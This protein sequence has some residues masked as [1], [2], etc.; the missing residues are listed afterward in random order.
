LNQWQTSEKAKSLQMQPPLGS[1]TPESKC[2][3]GW[4]R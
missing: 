1:V 3:V 4:A 2:G